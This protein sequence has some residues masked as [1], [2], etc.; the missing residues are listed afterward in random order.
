M[1]FRLGSEPKWHYGRTGGAG[2]VLVAGT[3][4]A[5]VPASSAGHTMAGRH[6]SLTRSDAG[7]GAGAAWGLR[8]D[9]IASRRWTRATI[10][11]SV[12]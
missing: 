8:G 1:P 3:D 12:S 4:G 6:T 11:S 9:S 10:C 2:L 7:G 5:S